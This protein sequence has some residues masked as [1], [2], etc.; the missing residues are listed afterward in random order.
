M[1]FDAVARCSNSRLLPGLL[2]APAPRCSQAMPVAR[3][4]LD[5]LPTRLTTRSFSWLHAPEL[6]V[7]LGVWTRE[8]GFGPLA[9]C[10]ERWEVAPCSQRWSGLRE[11][12]ERS[13]SSRSGT[14]LLP[15]PRSNATSSGLSE[16]VARAGTSPGFRAWRCGGTDCLKCSAIEHRGRIPVRF[17]A[18]V[19]SRPLQSPA[20][21]APRMQ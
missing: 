18:V 3:G 17:R 9:A 6:R 14:E 20:D 10:G 21:R 2:P 7:P 11:L 8:G 19:G 4:A 13:S 16:E 12:F 5:V 15:I 1:R